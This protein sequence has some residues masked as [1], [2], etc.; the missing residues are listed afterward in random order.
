MTI[1]PR[2]TIEG[3]WILQ[4]GKFNSDSGIPICRFIRR[5]GNSALIQ[6][7]YKVW[8]LNG[9][10]TYNFKDDDDTT[11]LTY[12]TRALTLNMLLDDNE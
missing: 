1:T 4:S 7:W 10:I 5:S 9:Y 8:Q 11:T 12:L 3:M 6:A 2:Q